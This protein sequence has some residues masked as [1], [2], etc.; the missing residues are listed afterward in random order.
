M[1]RLSP[2]PWVLLGLCLA[3]G[4][5]T[6]GSAQIR[7]PSLPGALAFGSQER[8]SCRKNTFKIAI[9]IG[10]YRAK[11]GAMSARGVTEFS[12][13]HSLGVLTLQALKAR[14]FDTTFLIGETGTFMPLEQRPAIA[15]EKNA[16]LFISLHHDSAQRKYF[17]SWTFEGHSHAYSDTF[18]G[19]SIFVSGSS[20]W[21]KESLAFAMDLGTALKARGLKPSMHHA[22]PI[23]GENRTLL[24]PELGIYRFDDLA[25]LRG[26]SMPSLLLESAVIVNRE[27]EHAIQSGLYHPKV[28]SALVDAVTQ[29]CNDQQVAQ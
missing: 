5:Q 22:E 20:R 19:Y 2:I 27:E 3:F 14:G 9:D 21:A 7:D 12:Y 28:V 29:F 10:H 16:S 25:V 6:S 23:P 17:S 8:A 24:V 15:N 4:F 11:P 13:N 26:A 18:H 1:P